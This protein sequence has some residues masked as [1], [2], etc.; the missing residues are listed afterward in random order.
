MSFSL[1]VGYAYTLGDDSD[2]PHVFA[3]IIWHPDPERAGPVLVDQGDRTRAVATA[4]WTGGSGSS[5]LGTRTT[6]RP[7]TS[8]VTGPPSNLR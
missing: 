8:A 1:I 6:T 4:F 5:D 2:A 3:D 7:C